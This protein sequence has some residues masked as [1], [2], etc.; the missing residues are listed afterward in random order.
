[1]RFEAVDWKATASPFALSTGLPES[2]LPAVPCGVA[3]TSSWTRATASCASTHL[4]AAKPT[5]RAH[6][7]AQRRQ[8]TLWS[9]RKGDIRR[10][11]EGGERHVSSSLGETREGKQFSVRLVFPSDPRETPVYEAPRHKD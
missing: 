9:W 3:L 1:M 2:P 10:P 7:G 6:P 11:G 5:R 4:P 8:E